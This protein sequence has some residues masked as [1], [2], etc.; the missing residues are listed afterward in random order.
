ML[1]QVLDGLVMPVNRPVDTHT[2]MFRKAFLQAGGI[3]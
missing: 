3:Q 2:L 1:L